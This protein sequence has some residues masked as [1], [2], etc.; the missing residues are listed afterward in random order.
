MS[1][2]LSLCPVHG[3]AAVWHADELARQSGEVLPTGHV[4]L[5]AELPGGGW[6]VGALVE[7]LQAPGAVAGQN[8]WRLLLPALRCT[9]PGPVVLVGAPHVPLGPALMAQGLDAQRLLWVCCPAPARQLWAAE[10]SLRCAQVVAVL[11]WLPLVRAEQLRRLHMAAH[12]HGKLLFV[13]RP[14]QARAQA[15][16]A[17]LRLLLTRAPPGAALDALALHIFKRRGPP[18]EQTLLLPARSAAL[19]ALLALSEQ[20][21]QGECTG[22]DAGGGDALDCL[23]AAA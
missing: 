19:A 11:A 12:E 3:S 1:A 6:P 23:A 21:K 9:K 18:L 10:Q 2:L 15:S 14:G 20:G 17:V 13:M 4:L 5:D 7:V 8:E 22:P 16:P